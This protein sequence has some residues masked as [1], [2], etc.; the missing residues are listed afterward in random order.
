M[1]NA[2]ILAAEQAAAAQAAA[3]DLA[4]MQTAMAVFADST[5]TTAACQAAFETLVAAITDPDRLERLSFEANR[6]P[7]FLADLAGMIADAQAASSPPSS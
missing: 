1:P 3:A 6:W 4:A 7:Q 5:Q 2:A